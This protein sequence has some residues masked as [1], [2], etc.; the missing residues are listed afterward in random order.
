MHFDH[1]GVATDDAADLAALFADLFET[2]IVHEEEFDGMRVVF[3]D[4][5]DGEGTEDSHGP[6]LELLEPLTDEGSIARFLDREG[7]GIHHVALATEDVAAALD[8][9]E[10]LGLD[11]VD[12]E[13]RPGAWGHQVAFLHPGS[14]GGVLVEFVEH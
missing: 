13:P 4:V 11:L 10:A 2:E 1:V 12:E 3:L 14:T 7:P 9:A 6:Y 8:G 5:G